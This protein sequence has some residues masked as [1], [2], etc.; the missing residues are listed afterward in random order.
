MARPIGRRLQGYVPVIIIS[1]WSRRLPEGGESPKNYPH[2]A[3][4]ARSLAASGREI[5]QIS[6]S[7]EAD[8]PGCHARR[9]DLPLRAIEA[10][11]RA[12][13]TWISVDNFLHHLAW[14]AGKRGVA[15][16]GPSDPEI[17]GHPKNVNLL[18][19]RRFLRQRQFGLWSQEAPLPEA[20]VGPEQVVVAV[21]R[22][23]SEALKAVDD[24]KRAKP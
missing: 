6:V 19:D 17:F 2:W 24:V 10:L 16:F 8:V 22:V 13:E 3:T 23:I 11:V 21:E 15:I 7:G 12:S 4:V 18:K 5:L 9:D 20:F 1:P 14:A